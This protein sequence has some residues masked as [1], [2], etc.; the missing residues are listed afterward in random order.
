MVAEK[1]PMKP[2]VTTH[3]THM[4]EGWS[5]WMSKGGKGYYGGYPKVN[6]EKIKILMIFLHAIITNFAWIPHKESSWHT[7]H[8]TVQRCEWK[9]VMTDR[10]GKETYQQLQ[11]SS[12]MNCN[13][14]FL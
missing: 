14:D 8:C 9:F 12:D 13:L 2:E 6:T 4:A 10:K 1:P 5:A 11:K 3:L 7:K